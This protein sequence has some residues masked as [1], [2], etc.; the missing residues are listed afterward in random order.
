M[1]RVKNNLK[2]THQKFV[3]PK[4]LFG[5]EAML[6]GRTLVISDLH[7]GYEYELERM[8]TPVRPM[9]ERLKEK[10]VGICERFD[11][12]RI[13]LN[14]DLR[15]MI[16]DLDLRKEI[17]GF[18]EE[19]CH[20]FKV[21]LIEGNHDHGLGLK[22]RKFLI[23]K[24]NL[25]THGHALYWRKAKRY[26]IGHLHP[27]LRVGKRKVKVWAFGR[28]KAEIVVMPAFNPLIT[29]SEIGKGEGSPY[30][31]YVREVELYSLEGDLLKVVR[32]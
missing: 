5:S 9:T 23:V 16:R 24:G 27:A 13:V 28:G 19:L 15:H 17:E 6:L 1:I 12:K 2:P 25:I 8:E 10:I 30:L 14:G 11:V 4:F 7:I 22:M 18:V 20:H 3:K 29:G 31:R 26:V 21:I 32:L